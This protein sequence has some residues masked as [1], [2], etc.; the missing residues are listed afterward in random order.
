MSRTLSD[1]WAE[2]GTA[3]HCTVNGDPVAVLHSPADVLTWMRTQAIKNGLDRS[4][5][6][7]PTLTGGR[8][9][10]IKIVASHGETV[11]I[12]GNGTTIRAEARHENGES[13]ERLSG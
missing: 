12:S 7:D 13:G 2:L 9:T 8:R 1:R 5:L 11:Q 6:S 10:A 4:L 3:W